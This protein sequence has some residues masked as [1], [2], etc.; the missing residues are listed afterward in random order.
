MLIGKRNVHIHSMSVHFTSALYPVAVFFLFLSF[1]YRSPPSLFAYRHLMILATL[2][3]PVS[4]LTGIAE[5]KQKYRGARVRIFR[6]KIKAGVALV[7]L[8]ALC[9]LWYG[10][11]PEIM[12]DPGAARAVFLCV[13]SAL[14]PIVVYLG[15]LGGRLV[16]GGAH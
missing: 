6:R 9:T 16:Y 12:H 7:V 3:A 4:Y 8:G 5:W 10:L 1:F 2:S 11:Q 13:N 14:V 15:S